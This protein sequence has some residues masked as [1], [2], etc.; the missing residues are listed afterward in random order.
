M[1]HFEQEMLD[2]R[3]RSGRT[4]PLVGSK[5]DMLS[6]KHNVEVLTGFFDEIKL[7]TN[8]MIHYIFV[9]IYLIK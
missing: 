5:N 6:L 4:G 9:I 3:T 7:T 8:V 2:F 1:A